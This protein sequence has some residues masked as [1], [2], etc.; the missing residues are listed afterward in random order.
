MFSS[1]LIASLSLLAEAHPGTVVLRMLVVFGSG[2]LN[3]PRSPSYQHSSLDF[4]LFSFSLGVAREAFGIG[5]R[6]FS[7]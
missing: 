1:C 3:K 2:F 5:F 4:L 6:I 7:K